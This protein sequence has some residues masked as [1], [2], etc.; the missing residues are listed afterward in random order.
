M[1]VILNKHIFVTISRVNST[2]WDIGRYSYKFVLI[3][4]MNACRIVLVFLI[5]N[6]VTQGLTVLFS[7]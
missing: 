3:N 5:K 1:I 6:E 2:S 7:I 4:E